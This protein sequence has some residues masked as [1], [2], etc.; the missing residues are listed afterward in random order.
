MSLSTSTFKMLLSKS[1]NAILFFGGITLFA[2]RLP[3]N[4][5]GVFFLYLALLGVCSI[6]ADLG[7]RAA[8][9]KRLSEG[10]AAA[11]IL[12]SALA[13]KTLTLAVV[14]GLLLAMGTF[15]D[16]YAHFPIT[17]Y[18]VLG[19]VVQEFSRFSIQTVR[20]ELRVGETAIIEVGRRFTWVTSS[21]LLLE[22]G[23]GPEALLIGQIVGRSLEFVWAT[24]RVD[25]SLGRPSIARVRSIVAFSKYSTITAVGGRVYQWM[26]VLVIGFLLTNSHVAAYEIAWQVTL[27]VLL[28]SNSIRLNLFPQIS[29]WDAEAATER[30]QNAISTALGYVLYVSVP[31]IVGAVLYADEILRFV[32]GAEYTIASTVLVVLMVEKLFQSVN[33]V[34]GISVSAIDRPDLAAKATVASV[35]VNLVLTPLLI[36]TVGFVGAAYATML[37][38]LVNTILHGRY[39]AR[40]VN[41]EIPVRLLAWYIVSAV[42]M[43]GMLAVLNQYQ[44]VT[45]VTVLFAQVVVG[46]V[47]YLAFSI[48]SIDVRDQVVRPA[49]HL[50]RPDA[51]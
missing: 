21:F 51:N 50:L 29:Q 4:E 48:A 37:S 10:E 6:P 33:D 31:A 12:G 42:L 34:I 19:L 46:M 9:E 40:H 15:I 30:I 11:E 36:V 5:L 47:L 28:V 1:A 41:F 45:G 13:F 22:Y 39:L 44:P 17:P 32:F 38:W 16:S 49:V 27:L 35:G 3:S 26:D 20:G 43:G 23:Y 2:R 24:T 14:G 18:L 25:T 7:V 8:L